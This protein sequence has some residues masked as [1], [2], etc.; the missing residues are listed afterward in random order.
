MEIHCAFDQLVRVADLKPHPKNPNTHGA[1]QIAAIAAVIEGN[2]WRAP[3][4]A[5]ANRIGA[6]VNASCGCHITIGIKSVIGTSD[7]A[8]TAEFVRKLAHT[9]QETGKISTVAVFAFA[10]EGK[11]DTICCLV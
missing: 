9:S 11:G 2:G 3:I 1:A 8:A 4:I 5:W 6:K 7:P 10:R